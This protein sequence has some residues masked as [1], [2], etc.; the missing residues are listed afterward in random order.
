M[1]AAAL[2]RR[3][4]HRGRLRRR[5][6]APAPPTPAPASRRQDRQA[7]RAGQASRRP[8]RPPAAEPTKPAAAEPTKPAAAPRPRRPRRASGPGSRSA[9]SAAAAR[10]ARTQSVRMKELRTAFPDADI[11]NRWVSYAAYVDKISVMAA[12]GDLA[13]LQF[14]NAFNDVPL[15][16]DNNLLLETGP[17]L[18][19]TGKQILGR[20][21]EGG[22]G[23]DD[24]RRQAV[25]GRPQH[26]RPEQLG[27]LLPQGLPRQGRAQGAGDARRV[28]RGAARLHD[29]GPGR[30]RQG[31]HLRPRG[32]DQRQVRRRRLP[33]L[34]RRGRPPRQRLLARPR[35]QARARLGQPGH[36]GRLGL[37]AGALGREGHR[38]RLADPQITYRTSAYNVGR[39]GT[40]VQRLDGHGRR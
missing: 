38:P 13:D 12:T 26:L 4:R 15:M 25:R 29:Q 27:R 34:R 10:P 22:L 6:A 5:G 40:H 18:E 36:E 28:R 2:A 23:L 9:T 1:K 8:S 7:G 3:G 21:A 16:M 17:L 30:Q 11:E 37:V 24:L 31:R 32:H 39:V 14:C 20:D 33:R 35:R 19:K